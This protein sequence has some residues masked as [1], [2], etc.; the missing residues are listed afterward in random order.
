M[1]FIDLISGVLFLLAGRKLFWLSVGI[2]GFMVGIDLATY[3]MS[4]SAAWA[5]LFFAIISG[6]VGACLAVAS[7]WA[8]ILYLGIAGGG[9]F[10]V[11]F[12]NLMGSPVES[13]WILFIAGGT[14]GMGLMIFSFD[15]A[16][17]G[18]SS[19]LGALLIVQH[20]NVKSEMTRQFLL[21]AFAVLGI[22]LQ[23]TIT[24]KKKE[25]TKT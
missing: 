21:I 15:L 17:T 13:V 3:W 14:I 9:Y 24:K 2:M 22:V 18:I 11:D 8:V 10:L 5:T 12:F 1:I 4:G 25:E 7:Q 6:I 19:L 20:I 23:S 16:L